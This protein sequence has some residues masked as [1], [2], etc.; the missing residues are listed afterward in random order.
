MPLLI[1]SVGTLG[2]LGR[3]TAMTDACNVLQ[4]LGSLP[5]QDRELL[6]IPLLTE[7]TS[8][9][10]RRK[11]QVFGSVSIEGRAII[12]RIPVDEKVTL[13]GLEE[14]ISAVFHRFLQA[15]KIRLSHT[16]T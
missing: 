1:Q 10:C 6:S 5:H 2:L 12:R 7:A 3:A 14:A 4:V 13:A 9:M 11:V 16:G 8:E 15:S